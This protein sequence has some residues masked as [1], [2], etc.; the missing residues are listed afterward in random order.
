MASSNEN[1]LREVE[2]KNAIPFGV[3][4]ARGYFHKWTE[5]PLYEENGSYITKNMALIEFK[6]GNLQYIDPAYF[7]FVVSK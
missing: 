4:G 6:D 7:R 1:H 3:P 5:Q 2:L